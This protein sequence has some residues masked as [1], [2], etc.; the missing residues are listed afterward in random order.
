[1]ARCFPLAAPSG[2]GWRLDR[3]HLP[4]R[5]TLGGLAASVLVP[6]LGV[7]LRGPRLV[8]KAALTGC[9][10]LALSFV[11]WFGHT[12]GNFAF[13]LLLSIHTT[14]FVY[15][16]SPLLRNEPFQSRLFFTLL[17]LIVIGGLFYAPVRIV[18]QRHW[19]IP[20]RARGNVVIV[21]RL[22]APQDIKR[23]DWIMYSLNEDWEG[24]AHR[25]GVVWVRSGFGCGPVLA[26][27]GDRVV[28]STN[29]FT[30][31]GEARPL[32]PHM[33]TD[34]EVVVPEK[35]WFVW[36]ELDISG[37]GNVSEANISATMLQLATVSESEFIGKPF[38]RWFWRRQILP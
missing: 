28:F 12:A 30:V 1:M 19:L 5:M 3:I 34:G 31:N 8:G 11:V 29:S 18:I 7:Y 9:G 10:L 17:S 14:G 16:C 4:D 6:G 38:K 33:P 2:G 24:E 26:V 15:Y 25:D 13:G 20:L 37:H 27:A 36:P 23:G 32:L 35:H 22:G 21:H